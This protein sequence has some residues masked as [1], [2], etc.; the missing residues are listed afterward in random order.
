MSLCVYHLIFEIVVYGINDMFQAFQGSGFI[1][2][3]AGYQITLLEG[4]ACKS[5][6]KKVIGCFCRGDGKVEITQDSVDL[7]LCNKL[8]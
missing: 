6:K 4:T 1:L 3:G 8:P 5:M 2:W 7:V